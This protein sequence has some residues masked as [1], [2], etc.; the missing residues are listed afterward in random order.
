M[1]IC[2]V[3]FHSLVYSNYRW[4]NGCGLPSRNQR[5][6]MCSDSTISSA[7]PRPQG[8]SPAFAFLS[9]PNPSVTIPDVGLNHETKPAG[10]LLAARKRTEQISGVISNWK[11]AIPKGSSIFLH[12]TSVACNSTPQQFRIRP[13]PT[14]TTSVL[15]LFSPVPAWTQRRWD[16]I[17]RPVP[18]NG[19]LLSYVLPTSA[20]KE[21]IDFMKS[22][23]WL[24]DL[25]EAD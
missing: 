7:L 22:F 12:S 17:G 11:G 8:L 3:L 9:R 6:T 10:L 15:D 5:R 24:A 16:L 1:R 4:N 2:A 18:R 20:V 25:R 23:L 21:E 19:S 13:G 14:K